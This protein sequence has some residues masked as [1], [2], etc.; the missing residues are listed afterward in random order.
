MKGIVEILKPGLST[1]IQ[2]KGRLGYSKFGVPKSGPMDEV[3]FGFANLLL[4]NDENCACIE[5]TLQ[6]PVLK[7]NAPTQICLT[8]AITDAFLNDDKIEM[9]RQV[10]VEK[11]DILSMYFCKNN[12]YGYVGIYQ[13][14]QS[15]ISLKSRS[16]YTSITQNA[17]LK[18][19]DKV[20]FV[21][22]NGTENRF[23]NLILPE[24][25]NLNYHLDVYRGMEFD[26]LSNDQKDF[27]FNTEFSISNIRNRMAIQI[28]E[29]L[30][31]TLPSI[32][33]SPVLPGT[34]QLTPSGKLIVLMRDCQT[35][36]GYPRIL[37][38]SAH[39]I[40]QIAQKRTNET[41]Q[42]KLIDF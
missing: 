19:H 29:E 20:P 22:S 15:A 3:A 10:E 27:L 28:N 4:G 16:F 35:T 39:A 24:Q 17:T 1:T 18:K 31:N 12:L 5:W 33:T 7:F 11:N 14:F 37:Q 36:G 23:S 34:I 25:D 41:I 9:Y 8:G 42:F 32:I 2:D 21:I 26:L 38:L 6:P 30:K 40:N 13:G